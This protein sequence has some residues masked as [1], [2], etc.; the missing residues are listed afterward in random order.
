MIRIR[1]ILCPTD[2]SDF[3][4]HAL[5]RAAAIARF[6]ESVVTVLHV[7][8]IPPIAPGAAEMLPPLVLTPQLRE[9]LMTDLHRFVAPAIDAGVPVRCEVSEGRVSPEILAAA[10]AGHSDLI[11]LGTHGR[12][13][14]E[15][16]VLGSV[17]EKVLR[18]APMPV[19]VVPQRDSGRPR[20]QFKHILCAIDFSAS[21]LRALEYAL[22]LAQEADAHLTVMYVLDLPAELPGDWRGAFRPSDLHAHMERVEAARR[23]QLAKV[24]PHHVQEYCTVDHVLASGTP[25]EEV[26]RVASDQHKDLIVLGVR[27]RG[28]ADLFFL[29][30]TANDVVRRAT[31]PVMTI[32]TPSP[33]SA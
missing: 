14:F 13:G 16:L 31:C 26:L 29:G 28:A 25:S 22:S 3:S 24:V 9:R 10:D 17:T 32:R 6:Y 19:L 12:S 23:Q 21:S 7:H 8:A 4:R 2:F 20:P 11:V 30:S 27:G 33:A 1:Q 18:A 15:R 5:E